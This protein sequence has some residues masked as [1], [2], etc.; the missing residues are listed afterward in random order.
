MDAMLAAAATSEHS[1]LHDA[2]AALDAALPA[3]VGAAGSFPPPPSPSASSRSDAA[4]TGDLDL[5]AVLA[6]FE[7]SMT[8]MGA[9]GP[10]MLLVTKN[11]AANI[12]KVRAALAERGGGGGGG[13]GGSGTVRALLE[14]EIAD[15]VHTLN[16]EDEGE[17]GSFSSSGGGGG[18]VLADPS[19][20]MGLL[21]LAR[22]LHFLVAATDQLRQKGE[23]ELDAETAAAAAGGAT[24]FGGGDMFEDPMAGALRLAYA[25]SLEPYH[26]WMLRK[27]L[28]LA[29]S[30]APSYPAVLQLWGPGV[31]EAERLS[32][33]TAEMGPFVASGRALVDAINS[34]LGELRLYDDRPV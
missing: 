27:T 20:A 18:V 25:E 5:A 1:L 34:L 4:A 21:W 19:A 29:S 28:Q 9:L 23:A 31:G 26:G 16:G 24:T 13:G 22:S 33:I 3:G 14:R 30:Q 8:V 7:A 6:A 10:A 17:G 32:L 2:A 12:A 15:G 11:D